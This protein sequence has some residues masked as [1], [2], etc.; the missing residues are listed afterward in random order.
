MATLYVNISDAPEDLIQWF[1]VWRTQHPLKLSR[2][3]GVLELMIIFKK[4]QEILQEAQEI[5]NE[6]KN[7]IKG[8]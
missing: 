8:D 3:R 7:E 1:D 5:L 6:I 4:Q 2:K